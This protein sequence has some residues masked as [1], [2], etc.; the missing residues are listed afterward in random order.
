MRWSVCRS[1]IFSFSIFFL[2]FWIFDCIISNNLIF[3]CCLFACCFCLCSSNFCTLCITYW[4]STSTWDFII[5]LCFYVSLIYD[6]I[7][8]RFRRFLSTTWASSFSSFCFALYILNWFITL[9]NCSCFGFLKPVSLLFVWEKVD[10]RIF[11]NC[12]SG[13]TDSA[14]VLWDKF[15]TFDLN[16]F[17]SSFL[18][19]NLSDGDKSSCLFQTPDRSTDFLDSRILVGEIKLRI[20]LYASLGEK[21]LTL[22]L[23]ID[24]GL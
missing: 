21:W 24:K 1:N 8:L 6:F 3:L 13:V 17:N 18:L 12:G 5:Y 10:L 2:W 11:S 23:S 4:R 16:L 22:G 14:A 19:L 9:H 20:W 15:K 7:W